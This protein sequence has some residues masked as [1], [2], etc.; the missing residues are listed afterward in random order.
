MQPIFC[1]LSKAHSHAS[2]SEASLQML[3][4]VLPPIL[5]LHIKFFPYDAACQPQI[6]YLR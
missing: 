2:P 4:E 3:H 5:D 1:T 6:T